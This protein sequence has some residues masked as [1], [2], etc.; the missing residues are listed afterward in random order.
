MDVLKIALMIALFIYRIR[1]DIFIHRFKLKA[2][3]KKGI[4]IEVSTKEKNGLS[5][6][7]SRSNH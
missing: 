7:D 5:S 1:K 6:E 2:S 3:L 4:E